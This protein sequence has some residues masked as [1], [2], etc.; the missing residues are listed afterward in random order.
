LFISNIA[1]ILRYQTIVRKSDTDTLQ[2]VKWLA[3]KP[4]SKCSRHQTVVVA[5][6]SS[7]LSVQFLQLS[8]LVEI[9]TMLVLAAVQ[10]RIVI[11]APIRSADNE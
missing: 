6:D 4:R 2:Q 5:P 11:I 1:Y 10:R 3:N 8:P 7:Q 9:K